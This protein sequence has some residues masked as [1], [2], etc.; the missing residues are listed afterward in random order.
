MLSRGI[1][2]STIGMT[3]IVLLTMS[4]SAPAVASAS[5]STGSQDAA[6]VHLSQSQTQPRDPRRDARRPA[7][8]REQELEAATVADPA[9]VANWLELAKL[10]EE[11]GATADA[12]RTFKAALDALGISKEVL[13]S[14]AGFF[15][16]TGRFEL[17]VATLEQVAALSPSDPAGHQLVATYYWEQAQKSHDLTPADKLMYAEAGIAATDRALAQKPDYVDALAYK[18]L[19]LRLKATLETDAVR[20]QALIAEADSLRNR[21]M[22]LNKARA[23]TGATF[24]PSAAAPPPP[25]PPGFDQ[26]DGQQALRVGGNIKT[27]TKIRDVRPA[28]PQEAQD[29]NVSGMVILEAVIDT[30]GNVRSVRV[31]R[32]I[33]MLNQAALDAVKEWRFTPT[34]LDGIPVPVMMTVTVNFTLQ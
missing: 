27:P 10:Q 33:P 17:A 28:Y 31:L 22:E 12:E 11:R 19:L 23:G 1:L 13:T 25:A 15:T 5:T 26:V 9:K 14:L 21:A 7:S 24:P 30:Q 32:S 4:Q 29:A 16:R 20:R 3:G 6:D 34:L 8:S 2:V 18:N